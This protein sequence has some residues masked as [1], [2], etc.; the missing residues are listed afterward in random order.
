MHR[1]PATPVDGAPVAAATALGHV[2]LTCVV[3]T[4]NSAL[5]IE[6]TLSALASGW[7]AETPR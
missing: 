6:G 5:A 2:A 7:T 1:G 3:P 4:Y